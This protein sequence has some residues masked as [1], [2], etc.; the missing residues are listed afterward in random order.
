MEPPGAKPRGSNG[1]NGIRAHHRP[2]VSCFLSKGFGDQGV[3]AFSLA[4]GSGTNPLS[5]RGLNPFECRVL[6]RNSLKCTS[7]RFYLRANEVQQAIAKM[8]MAATT[9]AT[10]A[11]F[12]MSPLG[13]IYNAFCLEEAA[14][15]ERKR[16]RSWPKYPYKWTRVANSPYEAGRPL[17]LRL[18]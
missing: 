11:R 4:I 13:L 9:I 17:F 14:Y 10:R 15:L 12:G 8:I 5:R 3:L 7:A 16:G 6:N 18:S 1:D 2:S